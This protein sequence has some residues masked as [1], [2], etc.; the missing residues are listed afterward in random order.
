MNDTLITRINKIRTL[1][2]TLATSSRPSPS[3]LKSLS[4][5]LLA[6]GMFFFVLSLF[7]HV[8][9]T[10]GEDIRGVWVLL[11]GWLGFVIF[12]FAWFAN[13]LSLLAI[14]V[15]KTRP[16]VALLLS[17]L[18]VVFASEIF[19]FNEIPAVSGG[20]KI[21]I[22]EFGLGAYFWYIA[23]WLFLYS[24]V[25]NVINNDIVDEREG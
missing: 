3:R 21:Y 5:I 16:V 25:L 6:T 4:S 20:E 8:F 12:Q 1:P 22:K 17:I 18:A 11:T 13:P 10:T 23:Q 24:N 7:L 14:L 9:F 19:L 2:R 15:M